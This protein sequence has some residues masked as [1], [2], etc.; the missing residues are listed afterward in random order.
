MARRVEPEDE[1]MLVVV[2]LMGAVVV[3]MVALVA[4]V[5][6]AQVAVVVVTLEE[7]GRAILQMED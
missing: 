2:E 4:V 1:G 7:A 6:V 3:V 5:E